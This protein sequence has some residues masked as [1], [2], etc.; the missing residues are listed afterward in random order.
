MHLVAMVREKPYLGIVLRVYQVDVFLVDDVVEHIEVGGVA[1]QRYQVAAVSFGAHEQ[2][3]VRIG[4]DQIEGFGSKAQR[5]HEI[6][7]RRTARPG[8]EN[9]LQCRPPGLVWSIGAIVACPR[10]SSRSTS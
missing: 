8:D 1:R 10:L 2:E 3:L 4:A 7:R 9:P 5:T 6:G